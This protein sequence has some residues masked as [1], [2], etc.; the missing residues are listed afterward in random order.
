[1]RPLIPLLFLFLFISASFGLWNTTWQQ[2]ANITLSANV[3]CDAEFCSYNYSANFTDYNCSDLRLAQVNSTGDYEERHYYFGDELA[4]TATTCAGPIWANL[5]NNTGNF[6]AF[7]N[8]SE[9]VGNASSI[10]DTFIYPASED[11]D[12]YPLNLSK[13]AR[14]TAY[15]FSGTANTSGGYLWL[16]GTGTEA[17]NPCV[18]TPYFNSSSY[19]GR[20]DV[21]LKVHNATTTGSNARAYAYFA[22]MH[23][24][25]GP[26]VD[27]SPQIHFQFN[28]YNSRYDFGNR[29]VQANNGTLNFGEQTVYIYGM[30]W[31]GTLTSATSSKIILANGTTY[32]F[33]NAP[34]DTYT[35]SPRVT[36]FITKLAWSQFT[37]LLYDYILFLPAR[38]SFPTAT[39]GAWQDNS[40]E[41]TYECSVSVSLT[42]PEDGV[43][44]TATTQTLTAEAGMENCD[45]MTAH[46]YLD[47]VNVANG[48]T[49]TEN[50]S[51]S[52]A[53]TSLALGKHEWYVILV[54]LN[55]SA[56]Y[57]ATSGT[58]NFYIVQAPSAS[59]GYFGWDS[60]TIPSNA[61]INSTVTD[62]GFTLVG[63]HVDFTDLDA[64]WSKIKTAINYTYTSHNIPTFFTIYFNGT[65]G[66]YTT[67]AT[68]CTAIGNAFDDLLT[69]PYT[70]GTAFIVI[71]LN[72]TGDGNLTSFTNTV[73]ECIMNATGNKF[74]VYSEYKN[75]SLDPFYVSN[76]SMLKITDG[77]DLDASTTTEMGYLRENTALSRIYSGTDADFLGWA[78]SYYLGIIQNLRGAPKGD[79]YATDAECAEIDTGDLVCFNPTDAAVNHT[80]DLTAR[81]GE[82]GWDVG[83][84]TL[85]KDIDGAANTSIEIQADNATLLLIDN[86]TRIQMTSTSQASLYKDV[87][88]SETEMDYTAG[89]TTGAATYQSYS[90]YNAKIELWDSSRGFSHLMYHTY[91]QLP[92]LQDVNF[93]P[94]GV[95]VI[96]G[97]ANTPAI[98]NASLT[99][100]ERNVTFGYMAVSDY[101]NSSEE[102]CTIVNEWENNKTEEIDTWR[103]TYSIK[104]VFI[105]GFDIGAA[106]TGAC[107]EQRIKRVMDYARDVNYP[108]IAN[109]YTVY[110]TVAHYATFGVMRESCF[111]RWDGTVGSPV[112][113][114]EDM[115]LMVANAEYLTSVGKPVLCMAF[116]AQDDYDKMLYD[117][118]ALAVLYG[119]TN[120]YFR[121]AQPNF[122][123]Q[124]EI[125]VP[126]FGTQQQNKYIEANST[127]WYRKYSNGIVHIDPTRTVPFANGKYYWFDNGETINNVTVN[128][129]FQHGAGACTSTRNQYIIVNGNVTTQQTLDDCT[130]VGNTSW[131]SAWVA[132][133]I[134]GDY[135]EHG[136]YDVGVYPV[137]RGD[138][139]GMNIW[140]VTN[141]QKGVHSYYGSSSSYPP[142]SW[143]SYGRSGVTG[144]E[145]TTNFDANLTVSKNISTAMDTGIDTITASVSANDSA[146]KKSYV[147]NLT[148][149]KDYN[150]S[151]LGYYKWV[152]RTIKKITYGGNE[153]N[154]TVNNSDCL[155]NNP[156]MALSTI[157][158]ENHTACIYGI[159]VGYWVR[160]QAPHLTEQDYEIDNEYAFNE[161]NLLLVDGQANNS[162]ITD[163]TPSVEFNFTKN[164]SATASCELWVNGVAGYGTDAS[165]ANDTNT[166]I[167]VNTFLVSGGYN[168]SV[169][170]TA[171]SFT[172]SSGN[173]NVSIADA[174]LTADLI[175]PANDT[176]LTNSTWGF[177]WYCNDSAYS[178]LNAT[179]FIDGTAN[180]TGINCTNATLCEQ[181]VSEWVCGNHTWN[182][183]CGDGDG[184]Y[185]NS[186][187][188]LFGTQPAFTLVQPA[189]ESS[190]TN[191]TNVTLQATTTCTVDAGWF[192]ATTETPNTYNYTASKSGTTLTNTTVLI[193][194][195]GNWTWAV[196]GNDTQGTA[197]T[198]GD[199]WFNVTQGSA[200]C[201]C[202]SPAANWYMNATE[203]CTLNLACDITGYNLTFTDGG[204]F[205]INE[206]LTVCKVNWNSTSA[207]I[208]WGTDANAKIVWGC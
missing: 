102:D 104:G 186:S 87:S 154:Y 38:T 48:T 191:D 14:C 181:N 86:L 147:Y 145:N 50:G 101:D 27:Y 132:F 15:A 40:E 162:A 100:A 73:A 187:A 91:D 206:T 106:T 8:A 83:T 146:S 64:N 134:T 185:T 200:N 52:S 45:N 110:Q 29:T 97:G 32:T 117:Y 71:D 18:F 177:A 44:S 198:L 207:Q 160:I 115:D 178:D 57:N 123:T 156:T 121:Y 179:L 37:R 59:D 63:L 75:E 66:N 107:F 167:N 20:F 175:S 108:T 16:N 28:R 155:G 67:A 165:V 62:Y 24:D 169:N 180:I 30:S 126:D 140:V 19:T 34:V 11:F 196:F 122:Q 158:D 129:H 131:G 208:K 193:N 189:N 13:I 152:P 192:E 127:D 116:G 12:A 148:G 5:T 7:I 68:E 142:S 9:E 21:I 49:L 25:A 85:Y 188:Y 199:W 190:K 157:D 56:E 124:K 51:T 10:D 78:S 109:T 118:S 194:E 46:F 113:S 81:A 195:T 149:T 172:M 136:H 42:G 98:V 33:S 96:A 171:G 105:D 84:K 35:T 120:N 137:D 153:M 92:Y 31:N 143:T 159:G 43:S 135:Q 103:T 47:G 112:Y 4:T 65:N 53:R 166:T 168:V 99:E 183:E 184:V 88:G 174:T 17:Q 201:D 202:P 164:D 89:G 130:D 39:T 205:T 1:M 173:F 128:I 204:N 125:R 150:L 133:D 74:P 3:T 90:A 54:A 182:V 138:A 69:Y 161:V 170:C 23:V 79:E 141:T 76:Y 58:R 60:E 80:T 55:T 139:T 95:I 119:T 41:P 36:M 77:A 176:N 144:D 163:R 22:P 197:F 94:Y 111:S 82:D 70:D 93:T 26:N 203:N 2:Y 72:A 61:T 114:Y 151:I 6:I